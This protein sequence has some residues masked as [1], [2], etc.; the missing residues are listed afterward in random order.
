MRRLLARRRALVASKAMLPT[1][2][3]LP[4]RTFHRCTSTGMITA[5]DANNA[6]GFNNCNKINSVRLFYLV[7]NSSLKL[8]SC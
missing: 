4:V 8:I 6:M 2:R 7:N 5:A 1:R 3:V